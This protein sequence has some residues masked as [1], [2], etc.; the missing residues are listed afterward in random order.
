MFPEKPKLSRIRALSRSMLVDKMAVWAQWQEIQWI[1]VTR[2][3][4]EMMQLRAIG[5]TDGAPVVEFT[6]NAI[7]Y[8]LRNRGSLLCHS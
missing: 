5:T 6:E 4:V 2:I 1:M 7:A 3:V 8:L